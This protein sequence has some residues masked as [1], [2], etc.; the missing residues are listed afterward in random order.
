M[1]KILKSLMIFAMAMMLVV[2]VL[3][4]N[5]QQGVDIDY[6]MSGDS[7]VDVQDTIGLGERDPRDIAATLIRIILGFLGILAVIII[8]IGGF[9][10][11]TA[12]GNEEQVA[13]A[14]KVIVAGVIGLVIIL[15]AWGIARFVLDSLITA[16]Q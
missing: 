7:G 6:L 4:V 5:A 12:A 10:W 15:A 16:T 9:K 2:P 11:M 3:A 1:N 8:L 14:R 13:E